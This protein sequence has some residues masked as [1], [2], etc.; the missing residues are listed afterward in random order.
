MEEY[1]KEQKKSLRGL[2]AAEEWW[3][4]T[5]R[6]KVIKAG[7]NA[8][9][10]VTGTALSGVVM[11]DIAARGI[12]K[13]VMAAGITGVV[14]SESVQKWMGDTLNK[15]NN[16][17]N[18]AIKEGMGPDTTEKDL[19]KWQTITKIG[20]VAGGGLIVASSALATGLVGGTTLAIGT[21]GAGVRFGITK[22]KETWLKKIDTDKKELYKKLGE[23]YDINKFSEKYEKLE[24]EIQKKDTKEKRIKWLNSFVGLGVS[25]TTADLILAQNPNIPGIEKPKISTE[26]IKENWKNLWGKGTSTI[27][28][29]DVYNNHSPQTAQ[30]LEE[31]IKNLKTIINDYDDNP[32]NQK[33][34]QYDIDRTQKELNVL[35]AQKEISK[36]ND[37]TKKAPI[38]LGEEELKETSAT[39]NTKITELQ[40]KSAETQKILENAKEN[41]KIQIEEAKQ[42]EDNLKTE[43]QKLAELKKAHEDSGHKTPEKPIEDEEKKVA[44]LKKIAEK[45]TIK[46]KQTEEILKQS[47]TKVTEADK[48]LKE[49]TP[50][51]AETPEPA[52]VEKKEIDENAVVHAAGKDGIGGG[53]TYAYLQ[54][55]KA[56]SKLCESLGIEQSKL[57]DPHYAAVET[58]KLAVK[59]GY[60]ERI[61]KDGHISFK[62]VRVLAPDKTAYV[63]TVNDKGE[64]VTTEYQVEKNND[65]K[66]F[67]T[68]TEE[69]HNKGS[70]FEPTT[71]D[72]I[73]REYEK[74]TDKEYHYGEHRH[75]KTTHPTSANTETTKLEDKNL[76]KKLNDTTTKPKVPG[77]EKPENLTVTEK[78]IEIGKR[79]YTN[80][81]HYGLDHK[82]SLT[83]EEL[84]IFNSLEA[85]LKK[86][87]LFEG[88]GNKIDKEFSSLRYE[89]LKNHYTVRQ[90]HDLIK[91]FNTRHGLI[92]GTRVDPFTSTESEFKIPTENNEYKLNAE[93]L[94]E[95]HKTYQ[96]HMDQVFLSKIGKEF[97]EN[98][99]DA[100]G[101]I[102][103]PSAETIMNM[104]V[105]DG[106]TPEIKALIAYFHELRRITGLSPKTSMVLLENQTPK[107]YVEQALEYA[108]SQKKLNDIEV[109]L[110]SYGDA[111]TKK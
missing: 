13:I 16:F 93:Q 110:S 81:L 96:E 104:E 41:A 18:E 84:K 105:K 17:I 20:I 92:D 98:I 56:D 100:H 15:V 50:A 25:V 67:S 94:K 33:Y 4:D 28:N 73:E 61:E 68:K 57:D 89:I 80:F 3:L 8:L 65:G 7:L 30:Q 36:F 95:V 35:N 101:E 60:M 90:G 82:S 11:P 47:E 46:A 109:K 19:K 85:E 55:L 111:N 40:T 63:L 58:A 43:E 88:T 52:P 31:R 10:T 12:V 24:K 62:E 53:I 91:D 34:L 23:E 97:W 107:Q 42:A 83:P 76:D 72:G 54:Q 86:A 38:V 103:R 69:I 59:M 26:N 108:Q 22:G 5:N 37:L 32:E 21:V 78:L 102:G 6:N 99:K 39:T 45:E 2:K 77:I 106:N 79:D 64:P 27:T 29:P 9:F 74:Y 66:Y 70:L 1:Q 51:P 44:E 49:T 75:D 71:D 48:N 14:T 87:T